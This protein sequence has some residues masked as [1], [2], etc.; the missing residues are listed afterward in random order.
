MLAAILAGKG[1]DMIEAIVNVAESAGI[2]F[3]INDDLLDMKV[4]AKS[5]KDQY[6]DLYE[7]KLTLIIHHAYARATTEEKAR[8]LEIY[9]KERKAKTN[10]DIEFLK[11]VIDKYG[12]ISYAEAKKEEAE[13]ETWEN[14]KKYSREMPAN[15]YASWLLA[16]I[17]MLY[18]RD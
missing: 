13:A 3:Q 7:G 12:S 1:P 5:G 14:M 10:R 15:K 4:D 16:T 11:G 17:L 8:I 18:N 9:K 6:G 2:A